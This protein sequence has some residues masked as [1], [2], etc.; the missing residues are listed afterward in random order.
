MYV[1]FIGYLPSQP[2]FFRSALVWYIGSINKMVTKFTSRMYVTAPSK[3]SQKTSFG[4]MH[5]SKSVQVLL[6]ITVNAS[7]L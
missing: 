7:Y 6:K 4:E 1:V 5:E 3:Y 2:T